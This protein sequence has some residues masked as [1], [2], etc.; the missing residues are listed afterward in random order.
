MT[1]K[2][3]FVFPGQGSQHV[4]MLKELAVKYPVV[5]ETFNEASSALGYD[6]FHLTQHGPEEELNKTEK[7]QPALLASSISAWRVWQ[8]HRGTAP[9]MLA[10]HSL[11]EYCALVAAEAIDFKDAIKLVAMRGHLM[12]QAVPQGEG[13]MAA[14]IGLNNSIVERICQE[15]SQ[16]GVVTPA[17]YNAVNQVVIAGT[18]KAVDLAIQ[19][20]LEH[21]ALKAQQLTVSVPSHCPLMQPAAEKLAEYIHKT[22]I[23]KPKIPVIH[24][25]SAASY[26]NEEQIRDALIKQLYYPVRW[27]DTIQNLASQGINFII[28]CGQGK[29]L[30]GLNKRI[31]STLTNLALFDVHSL[32]QALAYTES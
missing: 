27:V 4:G 21:G 20:A 10:G 19:I 26:D 22:V 5:E 23:N 29:V 18:Q 7:T 28:S 3:A 16:Q 24:N 25:V 14:I 15:A 13:A 2:I 31:D 6:L 32:N 8:K 30:P 12:Q 1:R 9:L 17:N 11:G